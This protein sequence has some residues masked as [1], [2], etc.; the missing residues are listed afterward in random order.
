MAEGQ[1]PDRSSKNQAGRIRTKLCTILISTRPMTIIGRVFFASQP[2][3]GLARDSAL[4]DN[5]AQTP[6][7]QIVCPHH[8]LRVSASTNTSHPVV[9]GHA[10]PAM[11]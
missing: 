6:F 10:V 4:S 3:T 7:Y 5:E 8:H 11:P 1:E 9:S 2:C